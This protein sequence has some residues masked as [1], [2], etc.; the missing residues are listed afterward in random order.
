MT[1]TISTRD[2]NCSEVISPADRAVVVMMDN[3]AGSACRRY[4]CIVVSTLQH[5]SAY[6]VDKRGFS[7]TPVLSVQ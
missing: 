4:T 6:G 7:A 3:S 1:V 2:E 5:T